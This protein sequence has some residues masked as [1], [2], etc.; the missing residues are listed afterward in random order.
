MSFEYLRLFFA[1][2][3]FKL[4]SKCFCLVGK[5]GNCRAQTLFLMLRI[6]KFY[7]GV[8]EVYI[9]YNNSLTYSEAL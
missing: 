4:R 9:L 6:G 3:L 2:V 5:V 7:K 1:C 8:I